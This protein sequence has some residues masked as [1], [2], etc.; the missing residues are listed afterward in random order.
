MTSY[1]LQREELLA[2]FSKVGCSTPQGMSDDFLAPLAE[3]ETLT[4]ADFSSEEIALAELMAH[5]HRVVCVEREDA[6]GI[7]Q[8]KVWFYV[9]G[10]H[11]ASLSTSADGYVFS[12]LD[13]L[14]ALLSK[15]SA[16]LPLRPDPNT[17]HARAVLDLDEFMEVRALLSNRHEVSAE[18][19]LEADG[20]ETF[21]AINLAASVESQE[22][23][24][25]LSFQFYEEDK[26]IKERNLW[27]LQGPDASWLGYQDL[28][29]DKMI[30]QSANNEVLDDI[31]LRIWEALDES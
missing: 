20:M 13:S 26:L 24:G 29:T 25:R 19:I 1:T 4:G 2:L 5:P 22:W 31:A 27:V 18:A 9:L 3:S 12:S 23:N 7:V 16:T 11:F 21:E 14:D 15:L 6:D 10:T 17:V 8:N 30:V 28:E